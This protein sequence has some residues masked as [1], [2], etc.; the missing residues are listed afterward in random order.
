MQSSVET[1]KSA[2]AAMQQG[3]GPSVLQ[4][5]QW[6][7][8]LEQSQEAWGVAWDLVNG[9]GTSS[10]ETMYRF[11]GAKIIYTKIQRDFDELG[12]DQ[13]A[14]FTQKLVS[15]TIDLSQKYGE[16]V[17]F[18]VCRYLCLSIAAIAL[19]VNREGV[20]NQIL[21]WFNP[22]LQSAPRVMLELL[23]LLPEECDNY[24][25]DVDRDTRDMFAYQL[26]ESF[27]DVASFLQSLMEAPGC[28][29]FTKIKILNCLAAWIECTFVAGSQV[30]V[31]PTFAAALASLHSSNTEVMEAAVEVIIG[32]F[33]RF[34]SSNQDIL[35]NS[36]PKLVN[37]APYWQQAC[38][39][40]DCEE[41]DD[42]YDVCKHIARLV[43][44][45]SDNCSRFLLQPSSDAA[46]HA[47]KQGL[48]QLLLECCKH[49]L[50]DISCIPLSFVDNF[51]G[52]LTDLYLT[53][54]DESDDRDK[55]SSPARDSDRK[56]GRAR[57]SPT[58]AWQ[59][60]KE[61]YFGHLLSLLQTCT[62]QCARS[63]QLPLATLPG[64]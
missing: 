1:A 57:A 24:Q 37:L 28:T 29:D 64:W 59:Y 45:V 63:T 22:I 39:S 20:V 49:P 62:L 51:T 58:E 42:A 48:F 9:E 12:S 3:S 21:T 35:A 41:G 19:Q 34:G 14:D 6:L 46:M 54:V 38:S 47:C 17:S 25:I 61:A 55:G 7:S 13:I 50:D 53:F 32:T 16:D 23:Y 52:D 5:G 8:D 33:E 11:F 44:G 4:A 26:T 40:P 27:N 43:T 31:H 10:E 36:W 30:A 18:V 56:D 2:I 15:R 60:V